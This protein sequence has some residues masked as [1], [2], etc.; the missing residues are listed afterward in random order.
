MR[1]AA[2]VAA[3]TVPNIATGTNGDSAGF[4]ALGPPRLAARASGTTALREDR[5][6]GD[7]L[8][9]IEVPTSDPFSNANTCDE[10][11]PAETQAPERQHGGVAPDEDLI[12]QKR[13]G[14]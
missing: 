10:L 8:R 9:Q 11:V 5:A 7:A 6:L 13:M 1:F 14:T 3:L 2:A 12:R 4:A